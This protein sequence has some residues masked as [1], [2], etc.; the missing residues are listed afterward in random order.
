M[1]VQTRHAVVFLCLFDGLHIP[2]IRRLA[3]KPKTICFE[4]VIDFDPALFAPRSMDVLYKAYENHLNCSCSTLVD[5]IIP[6]VNNHLKVFESRSSNERLILHYFGQGTLQPSV[7]GL[8]F[9]PKGY[10]SY[11]YIKMSSLL[12][13]GNLPVLLIVDCDNAGILENTIQIENAQHPNRDTIVF[14]SCSMNEKL[15]KSSD[16]PLDI[17]SSSIL[18]PTE[19]AI[20]MYQQH[21]SFSKTFKDVSVPLL[22]PFLLAIID[23][24][25]FSSF[26]TED[27]NKFIL[28]DPTV[29]NI[30]KG[31][32]LACRLL[33]FFSVHPISIPALPSTANHEMWRYWDLALDQAQTNP[34]N[35]FPFVFSQFEVLFSNFPSLDY[36]PLIFYFLQQKEFKTRSLNLLLYFVDSHPNSY[37]LYLSSQQNFQEPNMTFN[38]P[39]NCKTETEEEET[40]QREKEIEFGDL[41]RYLLIEWLLTTEEPETNHY[42]ILAKLF[43]CGQIDPSIL[44]DLK[45]L[46]NRTSYE[47]KSAYLLALCCAVD[48]ITSSLPTHLISF[49]IDYLK[50]TLQIPSNRISPFAPTLFGLVIQKTPAY[51]P[52]SENT[53]LFLKCF[54]TINDDTDIDLKA[55][56]VFALG[57]TRDPRAIEPLSRCLLD[58]CPLV[59]TEAL[60]ALSLAIR[61]DT[62]KVTLEGRVIDQLQ[63]NL[64]KTKNNQNSEVRD[65]FSQ[66]FSYFDTFFKKFGRN[67]GE[68]SN[69]QEVNNN[70]VKPNNAPAMNMFNFKRVGSHSPAIKAVPTSRLPTILRES[71]HDYGLAIRFKERCIFS[72]SI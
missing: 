63:N 71:V 12:G 19:I 39:N 59:V 20:K 15:P 1:A 28:T 62:R 56:V 35:I 6:D 38:P 64:L 22:K 29:S 11:K 43:S 37:P 34:A 10:T 25:C 46:Y 49:V 53:E 69:N 72:S 70:V 21:P 40:L 8:Y 31:F 41:S 57:N 55:S 54:Q 60:F 17:L 13:P 66:L 45:E 27:Y 52:N 61:F 58:P 50:I 2:P 7:N 68:N 32:I 33:S 44:D 36:L 48:G 16:M 67:F 47:A 30:T 42:L 51:I 14:L 9:Y 23:T 4:P 26:S 65:V 18:F 3:R 5:P 24:I